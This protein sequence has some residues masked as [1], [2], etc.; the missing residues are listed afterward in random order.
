MGGKM[1]V[2][3][4]KKLLLYFVVTI[5]DQVKEKAKELGV[6]FVSEKEF[7]NKIK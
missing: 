4:V 1:L 3:L 5:W 7:L 2:Q 6:P